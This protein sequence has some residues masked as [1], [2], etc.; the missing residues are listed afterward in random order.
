MKPDPAQAPP[1]DPSQP[2]PLDYQFPQTKP[3][4]SQWWTDDQALGGCLVY[5]LLALTAIGTILG[6]VW[7]AVS[8][9]L[10]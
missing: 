3:A 1:P 9:F 8:F 2:G 4:G 7:A 5:A 10:F 6:L